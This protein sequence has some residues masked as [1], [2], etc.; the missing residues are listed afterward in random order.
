MALGF[1]VYIP[2]WR[3]WRWN[4]GCILLEKIERT[5]QILLEIAP[6]NL[7]RDIDESELVK[8]E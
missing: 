4:M 7:T 3:K 8:D 5:L 1:L 6:E 2:I